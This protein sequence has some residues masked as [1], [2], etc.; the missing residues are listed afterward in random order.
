MALAFFFLL[1]ISYNFTVNILI[2]Y[3]YSKASRRV[4]SI[5]YIIIK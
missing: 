2:K 3:L 4:S 1:K 5:F